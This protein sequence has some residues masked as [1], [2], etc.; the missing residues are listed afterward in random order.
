MKRW[1]GFLAV[2][3]AA[4]V[5]AVMAT[6][7]PGPVAADAPPREFS[8][9]RAMVEVQRIA[10]TPHSTGTAENARVRAYLVERLKAMGLEVREAVHPLPPRSIERMR[11]WSQG[12]HAPATM[13]NIIGVL[14]GRDRNLPAAALMAH[15]DTVWGSPG[16]SDDTAGVA[17]ILESLRAIKARGMAERDLAVIITDAEELGLSG[18]EAFFASDPLR[19]RIGM[20]VNMEAR[21]GGG[22]T[23]LFE[24][25]ADNGN[26][27][28]LYADAVSTPGASSLAAYIYSVLPNDTDLSVSLRASKPGYNFAFIGRPGLYHS[29]MATPEN[30]DQGAL[31][32]M[33]RQV[34][35]VTDRLV[36]EKALPAPAPS[37]VFFDAY[38][39]FLI[40]YPAWAGWVMVGAVLIGLGLAA[41]VG[42]GKQVAEGFGRMVILILAT[43]GLLFA[44]NLVSG[45][46]AGA[47]YY[48][49]LA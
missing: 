44:L 30:L 36:R 4:I 16:A 8:A 31:Q 18:A 28:R 3:A 21:G 27:I 24:T 49:R 29:P 38:G 25:S 35:A 32:D 45:A 40:S 47:N 43:A 6:T 41:R 23:T 14:P 33:G 46:G 12:A 13:V 37:V 15:H 2:T 19:G 11:A 5:L 22:R 34:L 20:I 42:P 39:L 7:P 1:F 17:T 10:A 48:D 26:A 9:A